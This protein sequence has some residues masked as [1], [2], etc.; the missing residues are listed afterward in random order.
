MLYD[1]KMAVKIKAAGA[2]E[3]AQWLR[4]LT[5]LLEDLG[6]IPSTHPHGRS[7]PSE[8]PLLGYLTPSHRH[9]CRQNSSACKIKISKILKE[10]KQPQR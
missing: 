8:Y 3:M 2:R 6:S 1:E 5:A 4:A 7:K 9:T 10:L